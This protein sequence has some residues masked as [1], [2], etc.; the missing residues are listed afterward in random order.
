V[1]KAS[2]VLRGADDAIVRL[3]Y[4]RSAGTADDAV[5][6][7]RSQRVPVEAMIMVATTRAAAKYIETTHDLFPG[8]IQGDVSAMSGSRRCQ[9]ARADELLP[10]PRATAT[11]SSSPRRLSAVAGRVCCRVQEDA[12]DTPSRRTA[13]RHLARGIH[14]GEHPDPGRETVGVPSFIHDPCLGALLSMGADHP[15]PHKDPGHGAR[16]KRNM[17]R[18][19]NSHDRRHACHHT[20][21]RTWS[22]TFADRSDRHARIAVLGHLRNIV[23]RQRT[24][25]ASSDMW[26]RPALPLSRRPM[27]PA[28]FFGEPGSN[29]VACLDSVLPTSLQQC[30]TK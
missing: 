25:A 17:P 15:A 6:Q 4:P 27:R 8:M 16:P 2:R 23:A 19:S 14:C 9:A 5:N 1:A 29:N 30:G 18:R 28:L 7:V 3:N 13:R 24:F 22:A 11:T 10:V 12:R 20:P 26:Q 21:A